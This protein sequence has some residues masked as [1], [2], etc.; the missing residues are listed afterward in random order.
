MKYFLIAMLLA[1][2]S[3]PIVT[4]AGATP[5]INP[6]LPPLIVTPFGTSLPN[7]GV[8]WGFSLLEAAREALNDERQARLQSVLDESGAD[9][10]IA[11]IF[12]CIGVEDVSAGCRRVI[13]SRTPLFR[14]DDLIPTPAL[15]SVLKDA[16]SEE[17]WVLQ[18]AQHFDGKWYSVGGWLTQFK[19][20]PKL[21]SIRTVKAR[22][23]SMYSMKLDAA[24]RNV[25]SGNLSA[26]P[27]FDTKAAR[28]QFWF[29]GEPS[30][31]ERDVLQAP[32]E[33]NLMLQ[34]TLQVPEDRKQVSAP[35][36]YKTLR[37]LSD[38]REDNLASCVR[39]YC[40]FRIYEEKPDRL[41]LES[42]N[43]PMLISVPR[44]G[45]N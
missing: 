31:I 16:D 12:A 43:A 36:R 37:K 13:I 18:M 17:I 24:Q 42:M 4:A 5:G 38:L 29:A 20:Q 8:G 19:T 33:I 25:D 1:I 11:H 2:V 6:R 41:I 26:N 3:A 35:E 40:A 9:A 15:G 30:Q 22:Y 10:R 7:S 44:W 27:P 23:E 45:L 32:I 21:K 14:G 39:P 34:A 28:A